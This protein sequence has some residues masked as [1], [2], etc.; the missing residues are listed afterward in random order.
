MGRS[1]YDYENQDRM[2]ILAVGIEADRHSL[3]GAIKR[4]E[5]QGSSWNGL[6]TL[7]ELCARRIALIND[8][9]RR[10]FITSYLPANLFRYVTRDLF[11]L[12]RKAFSADYA[13]PLYMCQEC[14]MDTSESPPATCRCPNMDRAIERLNKHMFKPKR[15]RQQQQQQQHKRQKIV[16]KAFRLIY[17]RP[18]DREDHQGEEEDP[19]SCFLYLTPQRYFNE[20]HSYSIGEEPFDSYQTIQGQVSAKE[21]LSFV[22]AMR[23]LG[24]FRVR[25]REPQLIFYRRADFNNY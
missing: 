16:D 25:G 14:S 4:L 18:N 7:K 11:D 20:P 1:R 24:A 17:K 15:R 9:Q 12:R 21:K 8:E 5:R 19:A 22:D 13:A 3:C 2:E 6:L 23:F 10:W